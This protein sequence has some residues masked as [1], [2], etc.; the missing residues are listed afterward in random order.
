MPQ[1]VGYI[2]EIVYEIEDSKEQESQRVM[3]IDIG[4]RNLKQK[5]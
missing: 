4:V 2:A 5:N 3:R 1:G